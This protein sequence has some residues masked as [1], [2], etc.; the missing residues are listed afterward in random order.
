ML[1]ILLLGIAYVCG[2][3]ICLAYFLESAYPF[4]L[5]SKAARTSVTVTQEQFDELNHAAM[6]SDCISFAIFGTLLCGGLGL[7]SSQT[8]R[9]SRRLFGSMIGSV[10]GAALGAFGGWLGHML[11]A[12]SFDKIDLSIYMFLRIFAIMLPIVV[13][14]CLTLF[15]ASDLKSGMGDAFFGAVLGLVI[16]T[17]VYIVFSGLITTPENRHKVLPHFMSNRAMLFLAC[18]LGITIGYIVRIFAKGL[19]IATKDVASMPTG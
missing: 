8:N 6:Q 2:L 10:S 15:I 14:V 4:I 1:R 17:F 12:P 3:A 7:L 19:P 18:G 5:A 16:G 11:L 13:T 9:F